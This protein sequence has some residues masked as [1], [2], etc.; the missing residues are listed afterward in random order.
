[1]ALLRNSS[2]L[3]QHTDNF[4]TKGRRA[5]AHQPNTESMY[6]P[7]TPCPLPDHDCDKAFWRLYRAVDDD[8]DA[9]DAAL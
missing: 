9:R 6:E 4:A 3:P 8:A 2:T 1:M 5:H 7:I